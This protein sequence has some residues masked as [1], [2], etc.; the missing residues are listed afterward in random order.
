MISSWAARERT[1]TSDRFELLLALLPEG[2]TR[3]VAGVGRFELPLALPWYRAPSP[4]KSATMTRREAD[5]R[6][7]RRRTRGENGGTMSR[8]NAR[9]S[10]GEPSR[11]GQTFHPEDLRELH[12][13]LGGA[14]VPRVLVEE[15]VSETLVAWWER[16]GRWGVLV[17]GSWVFRMACFR[18][19]SAVR[20]TVRNR[21]SLAAVA[22]E[23]DTRDGPDRTVECAEVLGRAARVAL[24]PVD[25]EILRLWAEGS[26]SQEVA[27]EVGM[28]STAVRKRL[29]R[30][31]ERIRREVLAGTEGGRCHTSPCSGEL[32]VEIAEVCDKDTKVA[33]K[34]GRKEGRKDSLNSGSPRWC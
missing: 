3:M 34:E 31:L 15:A 32:H 4:P 19:R 26:R 7:A 13:K 9:G 2:S 8:G 21:C 17:P 1:G 12:R 5:D 20:S 33:R 29:E 10:R 27:A 22:H 23:P 16:Y 6:S 14:G 25:K 30:T 24:T 28:S 18:L 11:R